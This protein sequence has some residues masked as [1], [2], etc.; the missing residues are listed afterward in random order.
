M[1]S[2]PSEHL[3]RRFSLDEILSATNNFDDSLIIGKGGFGNV[4]KGNIIDNNGNGASSSST[5]V[6]IKRLNPLSKQG[7]S[8]FWTEIT[9]LSRFR[10]SHL[11]SLIGY[12]DNCNE[13]ILVYEYMVRGSLADHVHNINRKN[14]KGNNS[15]LSWV[16]RLKICIG[17]ARGL[18]Y[19]HT[20]TAILQRVIHLDVKSSNILLD[21]NWAAKISDFG[22]SRI[23]P[24]EQ[25]VT[26]V[27]TLHIQGTLGYMDPD[28]FLTHRFTRKSDVYAFGVVLLEVLCERPALDQSLNEDQWGLAGWG[29]ECINEGASHKIIG[30]NLKWEILPNSLMEFVQIAD[31]CLHSRPKQR[32]TMSEV[33]A[34]LELALAFQLRNDLVIEEY[35]FN[36]CLPINNQEN[37]VSYREDNRVDK[38]L[39]QGNAS[40]KQFS[41]VG[42]PVVLAA[43]DPEVHRVQRKWF[44]LYEL[45]SATEDF[46][47]KNILGRGGF[48][49]VYKGR[50][51]DGTLVAIKRLHEERTLRGQLQFQTEVELLSKTVHRNLCR[52][53]GFCTTPTERMLVYPYMANGSVASS[54]RERP[55]LQ[56]PLDWPKR[57][58]IALGSARGIMYLHDHCDPKIIHR[59]I[60]AANILLDEEF[61]AVVGDF[62]LARLMDYKDTHVTT[63]VRGTIGHIAP[64]YLTT[65]KISEKI[66]VFA[67]GVMLLEL[68]SGQT[69]FDLAR[70][71]ND[72]NVMLLDW[73]NG[74]LKNKKLEIL[75][76]TD[77]NGNY[78]E[79]EV[80]Q[81]IMVSLLCTQCSPTDRPKMSEVLRMLKGDGLAKSWKELQKDLVFQQEINTT[82]YPNADWISADSISYLRPDELSGP[83]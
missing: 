35:S 74:L 18:D 17:A 5:T 40:S 27:S 51:A 57:K 7:A 36:T 78:I 30:P 55:E 8:E 39:H 47:R 63:A 82:L 65:A 42:A 16:Q 28:Y 76:D 41:P 32:P 43:N 67:Y 9:M 49:K 29:Q 70:I 80:E 62:G 68:I 33:V 21:E 6:A 13:M 54:L 31:Q 24:A 46:S 11:V 12:C 72:D 71:A 26:D 34:K 73:V 37:L 61:E 53:I 79:D 15:P 81:L 23:G 56:S 60:K 77:L 64:E 10:H 20:G 25:E 19:L 83:R 3:S 14:D 50:L 4:Y 66:D 38:V 59:D 44:R 2:P 22:L 45:Q 69:A 1:F 58:Q 48:G 52:L 75:V